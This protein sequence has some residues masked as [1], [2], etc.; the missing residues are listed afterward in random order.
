MNNQLDTGGIPH[1]EGDL[2]PLARREKTRTRARLGAIGEL[3]SL[4]EFREDMDD[5]K[6]EGKLMQAYAE[7]AED[8]MIA[9][10]SLRRKI[11][12]IRN[13][14]SDDLER[15]IESGVGFEHMETANSLAEIA[16]KTPKKLLD[17]CIDMGDETG[18]VLTVEKLM[19]LAL[20]EQKRDPALFRVNGLL[21]RLARFPDLLR[22]GNEKREKFSKW[23]DD[24]R[25]FFTQ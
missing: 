24:G 22:W 14:S 8:M 21:S 9:R 16:K 2:L 10:D 1:S 23:L 7:Y 6:A 19:T 25:E 17:E 13:Y 3:Q 12:I 11:T 4:L 20:G 15:W 18:K 5:W